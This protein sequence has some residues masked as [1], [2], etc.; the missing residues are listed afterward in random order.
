VRSKDRDITFYQ[1]RVE[2]ID[3]DA[4]VAKCRATAGLAESV[5]TTKYFELPYDRLVL[6]PGY[7]MHSMAVLEVTTG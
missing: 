7:D 3:F 5:E 4:K 1:A 2:D 6:A